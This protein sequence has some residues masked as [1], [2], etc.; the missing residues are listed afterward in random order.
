[1]KIN[2]LSILALILSCTIMHSRIVEITSANVQ[3]VIRSVGTLTLLLNNPD[4]VHSQHYANKYLK[5]NESQTIGIADCRR[6]KEL[7]AYLNVSSYPTLLE[8]AHNKV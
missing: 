4:C 5:I 3:L 1:M 6:E 8:V 7:C 2:L